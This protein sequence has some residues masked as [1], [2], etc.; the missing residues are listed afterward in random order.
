MPRVGVEPM[1][2][3][4]TSYRAY[5]AWQLWKEEYTVQIPPSPHLTI[6]GFQIGLI[7]NCNVP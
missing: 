3:A 6:L 7:D 2:S 1:T 4:Q 5:L